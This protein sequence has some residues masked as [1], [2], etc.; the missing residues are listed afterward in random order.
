MLTDETSDRLLDAALAL[1][2]AAIDLAVL[3][4]AITAQPDPRFVEMGERI[5][6]RARGVLD[7]LAASML[8]EPERIS[9]IFPEADDETVGLSE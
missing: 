8:P 6:A 1:S 9:A 3:S 4:T 2:G 5:I 7:G